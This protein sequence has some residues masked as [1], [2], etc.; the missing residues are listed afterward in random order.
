MLHLLLPTIPRW[1][2]SKGEFPMPHTPSYQGK[3]KAC[4]ECNRR[5]RAGQEILVN[6][7]QMDQAFCA[8]TVGTLNIWKYQHTQTRL[9]M[10]QFQY[11]LWQR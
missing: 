2:A 6:R 4:N 1:A 9:R 10:R 5:F 11:F 3:A 8:P 7:A